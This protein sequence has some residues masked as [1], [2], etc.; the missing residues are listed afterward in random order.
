MA[1]TII[2][3]CPHCDTLNRLPAERRDERGKC[4]RCGKPLFTGQPI[5]LTA[6]R[7]DQH[8]SAKDL[9]LLVDFWATWCGPCRAMAPVFE[10]AAAR[11]EHRVRFAKVDSDAESALASRF[12]IR[13]IPTLVL[14][15]GGREIARQ[16]GA[17]PAGALAEWLERN[18][19]NAA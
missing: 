2:I 5:A 4:G 19:P 14:F 7:F 16:S 9:P 13:A 12:N 1:E 3:P 11:F 15:Q 17:M 10:A 6:A 18:V 8:A